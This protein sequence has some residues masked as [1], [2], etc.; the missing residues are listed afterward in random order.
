M[1]SLKE[2]YL[3]MESLKEQ[4]LKMREI[5]AKL[6]QQGNIECRKC[7]GMKDKESFSF[8]NK[9]LEIRRKICRECVKI[10]NKERYNKNGDK[11]K[12]HEYIKYHK[13]KQEKQQQKQQQ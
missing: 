2:E 12:L 9:A 7:G 11:I 13:K 10:Y 8:R 5:K 4:Y 6:Q 1:E 3:N